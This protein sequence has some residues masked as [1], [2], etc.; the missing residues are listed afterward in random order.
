MDVALVGVVVGATAPPT[1]GVV[2]CSADLLRLDGAFGRACGSLLPDRA[3][4]GAG[5]TDVIRGISEETMQP[6]RLPGL[7]KQEGYCSHYVMVTFNY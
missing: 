6:A 1:L 5:A 2:D 3:V 7:R 4:S